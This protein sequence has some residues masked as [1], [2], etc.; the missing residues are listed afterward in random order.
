MLSDE[1]L[2]RSQDNLF[3]QVKIDDLHREAKVNAA[4]FSNKDQVNV[5]E[6]DAIELDLKKMVIAGAVL[7][8]PYS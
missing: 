5:P 3:H 8:R 7:K 2:N 6:Q 4:A 1:E